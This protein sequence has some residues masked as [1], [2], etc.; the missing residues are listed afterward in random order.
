M[1]SEFL[2]RK[3]LEHVL[4]LLT[5]EN[6]LAMRVAIHTGLRIGDVLALR[7]PVKRQFYIREQKT[8]K[9]RRVNLTDELVRQ[10]NANGNKAWCFPGRLRPKT[11][12]RTRQAVWKDVK[13]AAA[14]LRLPVHV[15][16]HT[17]RK[18]YAVGKLEASRGDLDAVRRALNHT[19]TT[20]T[21]VYTMAEALYN[22]RYEEKD[23]R[24][25]RK[26]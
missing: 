22:A 18:V 7:P 26:N 12:H 8:R 10:L 5:P 25:V 23:G 17:A 20:V 15:S 14:A 9:V 2:R 3:E 13:R 1:T 19:D 6:A 16:P 21:A 11:R 24:T 4:R